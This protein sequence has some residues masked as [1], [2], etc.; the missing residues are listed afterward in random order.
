VG[1]HE[2]VGVGDHPDVGQAGP[3]HSVT[4]VSTA[5]VAWDALKDIFEARDNARLLQ[6]MRE[7]RNL[8]K[9]GDE[10]IIKNTSRAKG[11]RQELAMLGNQVDENSLEL[12][13][14]S[15]L[16]AEYDLIKNVLENMNWKRNLADVSAKLLTVEQRESRLR[17]SSTTGVKSQAFAASAAKKSWNKK[18]VVCYFCNKKGH[19]KRDCLKKKA[20][21]AK[22]NKKP[23]GGPWDGGGGGGA[24]PCAALAYASS[25]GQAREHRTPESTSLMSTWVPDSSA[26]N[27][28][29]AGDKGF[30]VKTSGSGAK[31]TL[32][33]GH[34]VSFEGTDTSPWAWGP[35]TARYEW[36]SVRPCSCQT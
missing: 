20:D 13:I 29:A 32:D 3:S 1:H 28:M 14:L 6:L 17:S 23:N 36:S 2:Q 4:A 27:H 9:E 22:D 30:T 24:P 15:V 18:T 11:L 8:K 7:R 10:N 34:K 12:Q 5:K 19:M 26:T 33:D 21:D 25:T 16:S 31:V 35:A